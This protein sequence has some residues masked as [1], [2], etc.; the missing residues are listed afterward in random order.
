MQLFANELSLNLVDSQKYRF[1][2]VINYHFGRDSDVED[3][4]VR[5][6]R[7]I[8]GTVELGVFGDIA[9]VDAANPR[10]RL[11][12]GANLHNGTIDTEQFVNLTGAVKGADVTPIS[13][14]ATTRVLG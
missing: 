6:M 3:D 13:H 4:V 1:G 2:P 14:P 10:N 12:V 8:D 5:Q 7:D 9:W 11:I